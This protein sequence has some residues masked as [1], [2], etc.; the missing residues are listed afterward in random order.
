MKDALGHGSDP[1]GEVKPEPA[2]HQEGVRQ[3]TEWKSPEDQLSDAM[4]P[5][6]A[7]W[8]NFKFGKG[9]TNIT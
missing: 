9:G 7:W 2:A 5:L 6:R 1:R 4:S 8:S 3:A